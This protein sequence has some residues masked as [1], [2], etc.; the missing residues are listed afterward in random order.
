MKVSLKTLKD[1]IHPTKTFSMH[2]K[3]MASRLP[4]TSISQAGP[5]RTTKIP[6]ATSR[7]NPSLFSTVISL[8]SS[9]MVKR[10]SNLYARSNKLSKPSRLYTGSA[11]ITAWNKPLPSVWDNSCHPTSPLMSL[12]CVPK[13]P[14]RLDR[15]TLTTC[16]GTAVTT[17]WSTT[18]LCLTA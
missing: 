3:N 13:T 14:S 16:S 7:V 18:T 1:L 12:R 8:L 10:R 9:A 2:R 6:G 15:S 17:A 11:K 4:T 5:S